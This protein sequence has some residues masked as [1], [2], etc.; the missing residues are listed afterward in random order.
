MPNWVVNKIELM[1]NDEENAKILNF[2]KGDRKNGDGDIDFNVIIPMP[3][4]IYTGNLGE[5]EYKK[6]GKN[7]WYDW[8]IENWGCKWSASST[9][10]FENGVIFETPWDCPISIFKRLTEI[11]PKVDMEMIYADENMGRNIGKVTYIN[12]VFTI[13]RYD[14][15]QDGNTAWEIY[16][17][18]W[19]S[20]GLE[21]DEN[22]NWKLVDF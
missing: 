16:I 7:N 21:K 12:G 19:G 18:L 15:Y 4:Y 10:A 1:G 17:D 14:A 6:Y 5:K 11:F 8:S 13:N 3:N 20:E 22:G 2:I 9:Y